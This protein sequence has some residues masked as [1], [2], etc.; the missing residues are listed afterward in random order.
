MSCFDILKIF[1]NDPRKRPLPLEEGMKHIR[2]HYGHYPTC[3]N[4]LGSPHTKKEAAQKATPC[5]M[6][7]FWRSAMITVNNTVHLKCGKR[8]DLMLSVLAT[9]RKY[10]NLK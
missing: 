6:S 7:E 5:K 2:S 8:V 9:I 10:L 3:L 4:L 1:T